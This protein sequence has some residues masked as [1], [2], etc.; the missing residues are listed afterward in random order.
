LEFA[1]HEESI[2]ISAIIQN[3]DIK[4]ALQEGLTAQHFGEP[5]ARA[6]FEWLVR[7][8]E[9]NKGDIP[10]EKMFLERSGYDDWTDVPAHMSVQSLA[11]EIINLSMAR[12]V[13]KLL[14]DPL[15]IRQDPRAVL[16]KLFD[17]VTAVMANHGDRSIVPIRVTMRE[18]AEQIAGGYKPKWGLPYPWDSLTDASMGLVGEEVV[19]FYGRPGSMKTWATLALLTHLMHKCPETIQLYQSCELPLKTI[20]RR[21][22]ALFSRLDYDRVRKGALTDEERSTLQEHAELLAMGRADKYNIHFSG[23]ETADVTELQRKVDLINPD[24]VFVDAM[25]LLQTHPDLDPSDKKSL[26][27]GM[28]VLQR[29]AQDRKIPVV[30]TFQAS[31]KKGDQDGGGGGD[32]FGADAVAQRAD[33]LYRLY[34]MIDDDDNTKLLIQVSKSREFD[35]GG[36]KVSPPPTG[37]SK[38]LELLRSAAQV[39]TELLKLANKG[40][41]S[42]SVK[43]ADFSGYGADG[44][45]KKEDDE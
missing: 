42:R 35:I 39:D 8:Y 14:P 33:I 23:P 3:R 43:E 17:G 25:Y 40:K 27:R 5:R 34:K 20:A 36:L 41:K 6:A 32:L 13:E 9:E 31:R 26:D 44:R 19:V 22:A 21:A 11:R 12:E 18:I 29:I 37:Q 2:I 10:L 30:A 38:E 45:K 24:I 16:K 4:S 15:L 28:K 7:Y 1:L